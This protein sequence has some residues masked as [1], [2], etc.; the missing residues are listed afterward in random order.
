MTVPVPF[1]ICQKLLLREKT[2]LSQPMVLVHTWFRYLLVNRSH[3]LL[4]GFSLGEQQTVQFLKAFWAMY[5]SEHP[6]HAV[7]RE[8][9]DHLHR[10]VPFTLFQ[11]E[12]RS[13][14][15]SPILICAME[16]IFGQSTINRFKDALKAGAGLSDESLLDCMMHTGRGSSL[17]SRFLLYAL[18]HAAYRG[19]L[20]KSFWYDC[21]KMVP[22]SCRE[23]FYDG[24]QCRGQ[25]YY[26]VCLGIKGDSP[27]LAKC[28]NLTRTFMHLGHLKGVCPWC[29]A[30]TGRQDSLIT[31]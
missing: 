12:G 20:R 28:G 25:T 24:V 6:D 9:G 18:P 23:V 15:K 26:G 29:M 7:F 3:L 30:G 27:A 2:L 17:N 19:K 31:L 8:H 22:E 21:W 11:D 5:R 10:C 1:Y 13:L 4:G 16:C 14:R